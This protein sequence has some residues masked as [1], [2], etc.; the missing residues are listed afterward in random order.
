MNKQRIIFFLL[1]ATTWY[2]CSNSGAE[3]QKQATVSSPHY[4][5]GRAEK[6]SVEQSVK[7]P[8]QL[9]AYQEVSIFPKMN[10][11]VK[12]V[13][14]D[15]GSTVK[16]GQLLM[17]LEAPE[18]EQASIQ[19]KEKYA[20]SVS[21][22]TIS[23]ENYERLLYASKTK[24]AISPMDL[25]SA[26]AKTNSDS[27]VCNAEKAYWQ[28]QQTI[29]S[30]LKVTA[31]FDGMITER[32]VHPGAL[33]SAEGKDNKPMLEL[34][35]VKH[36][37]LQVDIPEG[38]AANMMDNQQVSFYLSAF[39][40]KKMTGQISRR[41]KT[42]NA[43]YRSER[44]EL[45]INNQ[46]G[47]LSPGMYADVLFYAKGNPEAVTVPK[48]AVVTSVQGKY[49][50]SVRHGKTVK[51]AIATG[52]ESAEKIE[53]M[54]DLKAGDEVLINANDEIKEGLTIK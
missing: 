44:V 27:T 52:N 14:V 42:V 2:G 15:I 38:L 28:M 37:R 17:E 18:L 29:L 24:G 8:A 51:V 35:Q 21:D 25:A 20:R 43:Q 54:G 12:T 50:F 32:N 16:K 36:L 10:G 3:Q 31:P 47:R 5:T 19:A 34:R 53:V 22:Y 26:K 7:L 40:G 46:D 41:S 9:A 39:P 45:D 49:V 11:Y 33:V 48:S 30:Y 1:V 6:A 23:K 13:N 4:L